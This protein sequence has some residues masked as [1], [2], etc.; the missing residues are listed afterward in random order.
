MDNSIIKAAVIGDPISH[1]SSPK[2]HNF[3]LQKHHIN[4][5]YEAIR[6]E[7]SQLSEALQN[8][9]D[10]GFAGFNVTIPHKEEIFKLCE[11]KSKTAILTKAVNTVVITEDKKIFG[12]NSDAEGFIN[13]LK[14]SQNSFDCKNKNAFIIGAGGAARAIVYAL[15]K[16][17]MKKIIIT[18]RSKER[19]LELVKDLEQFAQENS[20]QLEFLEQKEFEENLN[21]CDLLVNSTSLGMINQ[22]KLE[23]R[24]EKLKKEAVV[25]DIVYKPLM[26]DLL[27]ESQ[28]RGNPIVTGI[29][30][31]V[32][33]ALIGF[34]LW[35]KQK[36]EEHFVK[37]VFKIL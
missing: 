1:S 14:Y 16:A 7:K 33:Q 30:M 35:F 21:S 26:T 22:P 32:F 34:E 5:N 13:N 4:G 9:I 11:F 36:P 31:L 25:Y 10:N 3:L 24:L 28:K 15:A 8:F 17:Q 12:H 2:I 18:N 27:I 20:C 19:A 23:I 6:V 37:E 29:G